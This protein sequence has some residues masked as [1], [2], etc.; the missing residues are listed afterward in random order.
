VCWWKFRRFIEAGIV[1]GLMFLSLILLCLLVGAMV[2]KIDEEFKLRP[3][4]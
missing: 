2:A 1:L 3:K 4:K